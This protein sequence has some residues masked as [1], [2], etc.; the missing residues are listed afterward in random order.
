MSGINLGRM[1]LG[2]LIAGLIINLGEG[3]NSVVFA[4]AISELAA[5]K[6]LSIPDDPAS[7]TTAIIGGFLWGI[8]LVFVYAA[9]RPR[10]G[11]GVITAIY[12]ALI[13]WAFSQLF[14][15]ALILIGLFPVWLFVVGAIWGL[16]EFGVA[17]VAGAW[18]YKEDEAVAAD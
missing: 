2:G 15:I 11:A 6:N 9:I 18:L 7:L 17:T 13:G 4:D 8:L 1:I 12:A 14:S 3:L 16:V 10:F 5:A